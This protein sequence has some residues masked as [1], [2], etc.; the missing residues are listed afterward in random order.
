MCAVPGPGYFTACQYR[1]PAVNRQPGFRRALVE[2]THS[3]CNISVCFSP[4]KQ[5]MIFSIFVGIICRF[6]INM[7]IFA[8][9]PKNNELSKNCLSIIF[10]GFGNQK[11][12]FESFSF[13]WSYLNCISEIQT[14]PWSIL[15][16]S[17]IFWKNRPKISNFGKVTP[18]LFVK[19]WSS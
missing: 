16:N 17:M 6:P 19:V 4:R 5:S 8:T 9:L 2:Q 18:G 3:L 13:L 15:K 12:L 1:E 10:K 11:L 14:Q 7:N